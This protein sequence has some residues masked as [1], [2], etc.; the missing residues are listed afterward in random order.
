ML[1]RAVVFVGFTR[2]R[3]RVWIGRGLEY[4]I[5]HDAAFGR[6]IGS[7]GTDGIGAITPDVFELSRGN[8]GPV[9]CCDASPEVLASGLVNG[10][11][12]V[13]VN[14]FGAVS[15]F[16]VD[17]EGVVGFRRLLGAESTGLRKED[18]V[19]RA[20]EEGSVRF[21]AGMRT[22]GVARWGALSR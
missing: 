10:A 15:Y 8:I 20:V 14:H 3:R 5:V 16:C 21:G 18:L 9:V 7:R 11:E 19:L 4:G 2:S 1:H 12:A 6:V 17:A 22:A 13:C